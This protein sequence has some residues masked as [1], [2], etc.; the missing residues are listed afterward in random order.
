MVV[1]YRLDAG[2][3]YQQHEI[4]CVKQSMSAKCYGLL[5]THIKGITT[6]IYM[7]PLILYIKPFNML[8][9]YW[10]YIIAFSNTNVVRH[11]LSFLFIMNPWLQLN[12]SPT[13]PA[14]SMVIYH[15]GIRGCL[16]SLRNKQQQ[17]Q[18]SNFQHQYL[19]ELLV[20]VYSYYVMVKVCLAV[21]CIEAGFCQI[22]SQLHT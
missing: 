6:K 15:L 8:G 20:N 17:N 7:L 22:Q 14:S 3:Q 16:T 10:H 12:I 21:V 4:L 13:S 11:T 19:P 18:P 1:T 5:I 2:I 9:D